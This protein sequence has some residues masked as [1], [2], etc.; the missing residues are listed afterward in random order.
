M[1]NTLSLQT[2]VM[3]DIVVMTVAAVSIGGKRRRASQRR[4]QG[5]NHRGLDVP[6]RNLTRFLMLISL[7]I[8]FFKTE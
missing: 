1:E 3:A 4:E 7:M 2:V 6:L 5:S 8:R